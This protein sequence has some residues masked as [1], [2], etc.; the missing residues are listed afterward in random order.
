MSDYITSK[1]K[2]SF[3]E[4][5][6]SHIKKILELSCIE[7]RGGYNQISYTN[8]IKTL[9]YIPNSRKCYI[10]AV[11]NLGY[12]LTPYY[13]D[14]IKNSQKE[15]EDEVDKEISEIETDDEDKKIKVIISIQLEKAKKMFVELNLL[16][17]R[18]DYLKGIV[19]TE[20]EE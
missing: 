17:K 15:I 8:G 2:I 20:E 6:L 9:T 5:V 13:D 10:Q 14:E 7:F 4:I 18:Q 16:L 19:Y 1:D 11:Q 12:I 3:R